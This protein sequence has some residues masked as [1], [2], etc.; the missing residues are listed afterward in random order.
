MGVSDLM[1][2]TQDKQPLVEGNNTA[3]MFVLLQR[4]PAYLSSL[5]FFHRAL[6]AAVVPLTSCQA[7]A[8]VAVGSFS[9]RRPTSTEH[10]SAL[11]GQYSPVIPEGNNATM[12]DFHVSKATHDEHDSGSYVS[13]NWS[14]L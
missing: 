10:L 2:F 4:S 5:C 11:T 8:L 3:A 1:L 13:L 14:L 9:D 6:R 12:Q 7:S